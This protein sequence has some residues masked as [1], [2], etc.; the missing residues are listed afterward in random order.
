MWFLEGPAE[1]HTESLRVNSASSLPA[2][3]VH[4]DPTLLGPTA[5]GISGAACV[6]APR[7]KH[8]VER[9]PFDWCP[10]C[11][12]GENSRS[13]N[14][15]RADIAKWRTGHILT[16]DKFYNLNTAGK[17]YPIHLDATVAAEHYI[18]F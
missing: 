4:S 17:T 6:P 1:W 12:K 7:N 14:L 16:R 15:P 8:M 9:I 3:L 11:T 5:S 10:V 13:L 18:V 2:H